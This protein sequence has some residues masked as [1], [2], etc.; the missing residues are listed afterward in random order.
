MFGGNIHLH[1]GLTNPVMRA[2]KNNQPQPTLVRRRPDHPSIWSDLRIRN[3]RVRRC[4]K[5]GDEFLR[6]TGPYQRRC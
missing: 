1:K 3:H 6:G 5:C 4:I 2:I